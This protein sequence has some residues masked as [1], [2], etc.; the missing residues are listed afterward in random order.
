[1]NEANPQLILERGE[2][3]HLPSLLVVQ[4]TKDDNVTPDMAMKFVKAYRAA[5]GQVLL[6]TFE[7]QP[8]TFVTKEPDSTASRR[9]LDLMRG[10]VLQ[11]A[12]E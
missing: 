11:Q 5:G 7:D 6:K 1:M 8:H 12:V 2:K 9:A 4:G 3:V 10:F